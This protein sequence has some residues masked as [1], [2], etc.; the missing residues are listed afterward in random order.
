MDILNVVPPLLISL[1]V[2]PDAELA[3][4]FKHDIAALQL[5]VAGLDGTVLAATKAIVVEVITVTAG[6]LPEDVSWLEL[7]QFTQILL[8]RFEV[9]E[10][11][12]GAVR[13]GREP[14]VNFGSVELRH[15]KLA[16]QNKLVLLF[17]ARLFVPVE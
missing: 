16:H 7:Q 1:G 4:V 11:R 13:G 14:E 10:E 2:V 5:C 6:A 3:Q 17:L 15:H 8:D 9:L 12:D